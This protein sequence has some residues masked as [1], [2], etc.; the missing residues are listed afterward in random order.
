MGVIFFLSSIKFKW[1]TAF[2]WGVRKKER[3][4]DTK[5]SLVLFLV[6]ESRRHG[7]LGTEFWEG[8]SIGLGEKQIKGELSYV[9][10]VINYIN[11][12]ITKKYG[13]SII[14]ATDNGL[15]VKSSR[16]WLV[17]TKFPSFLLNFHSVCGVSKLYSELTSF[18]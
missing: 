11:T 1:V 3:E 9:N 17:S 6:H 2:P 4:R 13:M 15:G 12:E 16:N 18:F 8:E 7:G 14:N 10:S 5:L